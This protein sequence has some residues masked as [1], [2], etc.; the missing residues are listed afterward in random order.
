MKN[1]GIP[2]NETYLLQL[3][4][5]IEMFI[6]RMKWKIIFNRKK[7]TNGVEPEWY[8]LKQVK[9]LMRLCFPEKD[10]KSHLVN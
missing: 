10:T 3:I 1:M 8:R 2:Q 4:E 5:K 9:D 7:E 6:K